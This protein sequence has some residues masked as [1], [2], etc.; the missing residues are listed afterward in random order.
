V[1]GIRDAEHEESSPEAET[2]I[3]TRLSCSLVGQHQFIR[4][5]PGTFAH[6]IYNCTDFEEVF[7]CNYGFNPLYRHIFSEGPMK[8]S[9]IDDDEAVRII[10][11]P[12]HRFYIA[13]LFLPQMISKP[14]ATHPLIRAYVKSSAEF[15]RAKS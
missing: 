12:D 14:G 5:Q 8:V 13:T 2:L 4:L 1:L 6:R 9:G 15:K 7:A 10:E 3:V 11:L